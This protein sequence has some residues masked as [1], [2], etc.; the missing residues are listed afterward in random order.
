MTLSPR[1]QRHLRPHGILLPTM[2]R[3]GRSRRQE[4]AAMAYVYGT[5]NS[6]TLNA[7]DGVTSG[8]DKIFG[9]A[10]NDRIYGLGGND[11]IIGGH[12]AD[13][14]DGG[15][16]IDT[17][18][19]IDSGTGV[20]ASLLPS[21]VGQ[22]GTADGDMLVSIEN[23]TGS[24]HDDYLE[25]NDGANVLRGMAG[26]DYIDAFGGADTV[27]GGT[28]NDILDGAAG[29][30]ILDGGTGTD[31]LAG[32]T[33]GDKFVWA[34]VEDTSVDANAADVLD[35][36]DYAEGDRI[37]LSLI[38]ADVYAAGNQAFTFIGAAPFSGTP[39]EINYVEVDGNTVIQLQTGTS[40]DVEAVIRF[41]GS[42]APE[43]SWFVL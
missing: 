30:D 35:D 23:L 19:Y 9:L 7:L 26:N 6:E 36:F 27:Y 37:D 40:A 18:S 25:G 15:S 20:Y 11:E 8:A 34:S 3:D 2:G 1:E 39:G 43:A 24:A 10:G 38:D 4:D 32:G 29:N 28:G 16:G 17:A 14:I 12:G 22:L 31:F 42:F 21:V 41:N 5:S 13:H 33:G